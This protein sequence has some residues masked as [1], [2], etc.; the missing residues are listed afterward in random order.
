MSNL[1]RLCVLAVCILWLTTAPTLAAASPATQ[2]QPDAPDGPDAFSITVDRGPGSI[3]YVGENIRISYAAPFY[4]AVL[5]I[6]RDTV[7]GSSLLASGVA[8]GPGFIDRVVSAP[9]GPRNYRLVL[10]NGNVILGQTSVS[11][12]VADQVTLTADRG[13]GGVYVLGDPITLSY[14][15]SRAMRVVIIG[16]PANGQ[17]YD[18]LEQTYNS[19][20]SLS[21]SGV[22]GREPGP[23][24]YLILG[25]VNGVPVA[26]A[27]A[28][29]LVLA[30]AE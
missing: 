11:I 17:A 16:Q 28:N 10:L 25:Y 8:Y 7:E 6:Y 9:T 29:I 22:V 2:S 3:Y 19:A 14:T 24:T 5:A 12:T 20:V 13:E 27:H 18:V 26:N 15:T 4:P 1:T 21:I 23:R 30:N